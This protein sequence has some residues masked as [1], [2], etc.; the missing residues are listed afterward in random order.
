[1]L[2]PSGV[3]GEP[4]VGGQLRPTHQSREPQLGGGNPADLPVR[5]MAVAGQ[6]PESQLG[7]GE[8]I[9]D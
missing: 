2:G 9:G 4:R 3:V 6:G 5:L 1:M 7:L 8:E